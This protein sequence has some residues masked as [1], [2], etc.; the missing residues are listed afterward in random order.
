M[1]LTL[2]ETAAVCAI[3]LLSG[4]VEAVTVPPPI[5]QMPLSLTNYWFFDSDGNPLPYGGQANGEPERYA[6]LYPTSADHEWR[7]AG[8]IQDWTKLYEGWDSWTTAVSF[9]WQGEARAVACFDN[10]GDED[11]R[12]PFF[13]ERYGLWIIPV[14]IL[15]GEPVY[16]LVWDWAIDMTRIEEID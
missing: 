15:T 8:C 2:C 3:M 4:S 14:D 7:V 6:N 11:Y 10:F 1:I 12:R 16:G 13:H 9:T 5:S